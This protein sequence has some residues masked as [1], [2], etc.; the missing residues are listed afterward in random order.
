MQMWGWHAAVSHRLH[1]PCRAE[2]HLFLLNGQHQVH[3]LDLH[4]LPVMFAD[5]WICY[6]IDYQDFFSLCRS[7]GRC[8]LLY[9][10]HRPWRCTFECDCDFLNKTYKGI[11]IVSKQILR[12][13]LSIHLTEVLPFRYSK[14]IA[15][16]YG[17]IKYPPI[18]CFLKNKLVIIIILWVSYNG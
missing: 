1:A 16:P 11:V 17:Q 2:Q 9:H 10:M 7:L 6:C 8:F 4:C 18:F 13:S 3:S 15:I 14:N 5:Y 12:T